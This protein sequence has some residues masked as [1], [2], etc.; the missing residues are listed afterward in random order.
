MKMYGKP[1]ME[2]ANQVADIGASLTQTKADVEA[3]LETARKGFSTL[4]GG[5]QD[6]AL[7]KELEDVHLQVMRIEELQK[8]VAGLGERLPRHDALPQLA[9]RFESQVRS[10]AQRIDDSS[11]EQTHAIEKIARH[12]T[13]GANQKLAH[14][15]EAA[16][17]K[18]A[19]QLE[20]ANEKATQQL[21][22][23]IQKL[24]TDLDKKKGPDLDALEAGVREIQ[25][26][27]AG[28][29]TASAQI[30]NTLRSVGS[31]VAAPASQPA[32]SQPA[33]GTPAAKEPVAAAAPAAHDGG[34][35]NDAQAGVAQNQTG[36]RAASGKNVL[37]AIAKLKQMKQ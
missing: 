22:A 2:I 35:S 17:E 29:A 37:G 14:Q 25:R 24:R 31:R 1:L 3:V 16:N 18:M 34:T 27:V 8:S 23:A 30:Q 12:D 15:F 6:K 5:K 11:R 36:S 4:E 10:L 32:A 20:A 33:A 26:E 21:A 28:L 19:Q 13:A 9:E 7:R